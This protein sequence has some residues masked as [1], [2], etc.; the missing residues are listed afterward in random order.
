MNKANQAIDDC[1]YL[2]NAFRD[3]PDG[4]Q[5]V[6]LDMAK[7]LG[8]F[9]LSKHFEL[10]RAIAAL[11]FPRAANALESKGYVHYAAQMNDMH[12]EIH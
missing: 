11:D 6:L 7:E 1:E 9:R 8:A 10:R 2:F 12:P 3:L 5:H 4:I